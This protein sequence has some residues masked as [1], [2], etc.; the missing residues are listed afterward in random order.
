[1]TMTK[2]REDRV[3]EGL[4]SR[5]RKAHMRLLR[6]GA[7]SKLGRMI[8]EAIL[9]QTNCEPSAIRGGIELLEEIMR[10]QDSENVQRDIVRLQELM[11]ILET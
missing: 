8:A 11:E 7:F 4:E 6:D 2:Q 3:T 10:S 5:L 9:A 1:V